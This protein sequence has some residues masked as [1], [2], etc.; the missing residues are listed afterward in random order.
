MRQELDRG[1][2]M[3]LRRCM[4]VGRQGG[5]GEERREAKGGSVWNGGGLRPRMTFQAMKADVFFRS[6]E[7]ARR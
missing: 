6:M 5:R 4:D 3:V 2:E 1:A 7:E